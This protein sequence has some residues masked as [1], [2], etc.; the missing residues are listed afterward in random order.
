MWIVGYEWIP[1]SI[2]FPLAPLS[3]LPFAYTLS[4]IFYNENLAYLVTMMCI[5]F[6]NGLI[7]METWNNRW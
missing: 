5:W 2:I 4:M 7:A 6:V 1:V 3:V